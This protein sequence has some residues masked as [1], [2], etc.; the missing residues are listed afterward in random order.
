MNRPILLFVLAAAVGLFA[1]AYA[2]LSIDVSPLRL[3]VHARP[4]D[5]YTDAVRVVN[6]GKEPV[7]LRAYVEDWYLDEVGTPIFRPAGTLD[8]TASLWVEA[9]PADLLIR[10]GETEFVRYTIRIPEDAREGGYHGSLLLESLPLNRA[11]QHTRMMF[12]QGRIACMLYVTVG[13]PQRSAVITALVPTE[14]NGK[15]LVRLQVENTGADFIR[16]AG[17]LDFVEEEAILGEPLR[18]P[19]VPVLPGAS[20]WVELEI[21]ADQY[22]AEALARVTIDLE[23]IGQLVGECPLSTATF[24]AQ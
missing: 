4:G 17:N 16:L 1:P 18:L 9:A 15:H 19:D 23:G 12:I 20:R 2:D 7:R 8:G 21:P 6:S 11:E 5:E 14:R 13:D 10:P 24:R 22:R 3:H